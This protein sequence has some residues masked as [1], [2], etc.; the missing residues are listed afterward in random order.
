MIISLPITDVKKFDQCFS[1]P[2]CIIKI[3]DRFLFTL[4]KSI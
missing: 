4:E 1:L 2:V 3:I